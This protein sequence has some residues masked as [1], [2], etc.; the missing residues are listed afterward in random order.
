MHYEIIDRYF[1][2]FFVEIQQKTKLEKCCL[3]ARLWAPKPVYRSPKRPGYVPANSHRYRISNL[4]C[5]LKNQTSPCLLLNK[6]FN[7]KEAEWKIEY[8]TR[9]WRDEPWTSDHI[10]IAN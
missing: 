10:R 1:N 4:L 7:K 5:Q 8:F 3:C 9:F 6:N 2:V